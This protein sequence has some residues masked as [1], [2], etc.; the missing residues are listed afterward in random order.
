M[1]LQDLLIDPGTSPTEKLT[2]LI[3]TAAKSRIRDTY[4]AEE[5]MKLTKENILAQASEAMM[6][7]AN[8]STQGVL[9]I[10]G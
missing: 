3:T 10:L 8:Q 6:A 2:K 4:M 1:T 5:M 9:S 7:Q